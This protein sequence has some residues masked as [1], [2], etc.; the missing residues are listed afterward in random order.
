ML[1]DPSSSSLFQETF[2]KKVMTTTVIGN[3]D[4]ATVDEVIVPN[5]QAESVWSKLKSSLLDADPYV[6]YPTKKNTNGNIKLSDA[7]NA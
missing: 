3:P 2:K 5:T 7:M 4:A 6:C 1:K